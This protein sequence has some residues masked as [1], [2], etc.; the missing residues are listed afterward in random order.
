MLEFTSAET[1]DTKGH[2]LQ[3]ERER[4]TEG[5]EEHKNYRCTENEF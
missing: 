3:K 5:K 1:V 2:T 4:E